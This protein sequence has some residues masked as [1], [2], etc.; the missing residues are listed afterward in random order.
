MNKT[1]LVVFP[2]LVMLCACSL[3][4]PKDHLLQPG[5]FQ[6]IVFKAPAPER[7]KLP[8]GMIVYLLED[9]E[10]PLI[11]VTASIRT[12]S[13]H[14]PAELAGLA[15][16]TGTAMRTGGTLHMTAEEVDRRL[17]AM[18]AQLGVGL[19]LEQGSAS[20]SVL[21][22]D[23]EKAF[24]V[25]SAVLMQPVFEKERFE[26]ARATMCQGLRQLPDNPQNLAFREFK[27]LLYAGNPRGI[28]PT[29]S[30]VERI[31]RADL[32]GFHRKFFHPENIMLA[33]S[34]DFSRDSMLAHIKKEF[35]SCPRS[36]DSVTVI[37]P[38]RPLAAMQ[39]YHLQKQLSQSTIVMGHFAPPKNHPDYFTFQVLDF[40]I[41]SGGF[42]SRLFSQVR[43][44]QGL[45][46]SVG[47]FYRGA[48]DY[49]VFGAFCMTKADSTHRAASLILH[50]L[51]TIK[52]GELSEQEL[53]WA[54]E[55]I[56]NNFIFSFT[57]SAQITAQQMQLEY[58]G[59]PPDFIR[60]APDKIRAVTMKDLMRVADTW[61]NP[62]RI[63]IL[64]I[65]DAEHIDVKPEAWEW[66]SA[67]T[68]QS[69]IIH[70]KQ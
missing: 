52:K 43:T 10:L 17:E 36:S 40:I 48:T 2:F 18:S 16:L 27:K 62:D 63:L 66:G 11:N 65:G 32:A 8:N 5:S 13:I 56:L 60:T 24:S 31:K 67:A 20:L 68:I 4:H 3:T 6:P 12:G 19:G 58:D 37:P 64:V 35:G 44:A 28:L 34:G 26:I 38:P 1:A 22:D 46:Y 23:F 57:S 51:G 70:E 59:L 55:A 47:S 53:Q 45:A 42:T 30:S 50:T 49:G 39:L 61:L 21:K 69:D 33:I 14:E 54:K 15:A 25:F 9:H 7:I 29:I 41:G